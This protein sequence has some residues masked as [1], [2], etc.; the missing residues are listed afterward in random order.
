VVDWPAATVA[1]I[2]GDEGTALRLLGKLNSLPV[3]RFF[4]PYARDNVSGD[5]L[6]AAHPLYAAL[7]H[8]VSR[9]QE[10][11]NLLIN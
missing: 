2:A 7:C 8:E 3:A 4:R 5:H 10:S 9:W 1:L 11:Y 6:S